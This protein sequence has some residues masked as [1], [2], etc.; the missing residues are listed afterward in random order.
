MKKKYLFAAAISVVS[1]VNYQGVKAQTK[2]GDAPG[3]SNPNAYLQLGESAGNATKGLLLPKVA[4][5]STSNAAPMTGHV[6]GMHIYNTATAGSGATA[7]TPGEYYNDGT[8][9]VRVGTGSTTTTN[10]NNIYGPGVPGG[11]GNPGD[12]YTDTL[13]SSNTLGQ[14]WVYQNNTWVS[15]TSSS[16]TAWNIAGTTNDANGDKFSR[17]YRNGYV[18][19]GGHPGGN[20]DAAYNFSVKNNAGNVPLAVVAPGYT[21]AA[22]DAGTAALRLARPGT[23]G[24]KLPASADLSLGSYGTTVNAESRLDISLGNSAAVPDTKVMSLLGNGS[25]GV[26]TTAPLSRFHISR[27]NDGAPFTTANVGTA[28]LVLESKM[29]NAPVRLLLGS[30]NSVGGT[31]TGNNIEFW[32]NSYGGGMGQVAK[33]NSISTQGSS[34]GKSYGN[35]VFSTSNNTLAPTE[36]MRITNDGNVGIGTTDPAGKLHLLG[37]NGKLV[38]DNGTGAT[39][40]IGIEFRNGDVTGS[41][42]KNAIISKG[43]NSWKRADMFFVLDGAADD[44][45]YDLSTDTKMFINAES[46][47]VGV[48]TTSPY[49]K[50]DVAGNIYTAPHGSNNLHDISEQGSRFIGNKSGNTADGFTG[51]ETEVLG[52]S[53]GASKDNVSRIHFNTWGN[54]ISNSRRV[55]TINEYG[56]VGIGTTTPT[57]KL[58]VAGKVKIADGT[59]G[60]GKILTSDANG[61]ASW[62][63]GGGKPHIYNGQWGN[64][65]TTPTAIFGGATIPDGTAIYIKT[66]LGYCGAN[67]AIFLVYSGKLYEVSESTYNSMGGWNDNSNYIHSQGWVAHLGGKNG[68]AHF[69]IQ[70]VNGQ[71]LVSMSDPAYA[72]QF[73]IAATF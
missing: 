69:D 66:T 28:D 63:S 16:K 45:P 9:W 65:T 14:Q 12:I 34:N 61:V 42:P 47:N 6:T 20:G 23:A 50:L 70:L 30:N 32:A 1:C 27:G 2:I 17:V 68:Y 72:D 46:G 55:M 44:G 67:S 24:T 40:N 41:K 4:L 73:F 39:S 22:V 43:Y 71:L 48:G 59:Q 64:V 56:N 8:Q 52:I 49:A 10:N 26:G 51:M 36:A 37:N 13:S 38:I 53:G 11:T 5:T 25:V 60:A 35:L 29:N 3:A 21:T 7:V 15:Y 33:I 31:T 54:S 18:N 19:I 62:Q 57:A 58:D